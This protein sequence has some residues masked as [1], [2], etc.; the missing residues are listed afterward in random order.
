MIQKRLNPLYERLMMK[1]SNKQKALIHVAKSK[2]GLSEDGYRDLLAGFGVES[3]RDLSIDNFDGIMSRLKALGFESTS[4]YRRPAENKRPL[5]SKVHALMSE[6]N[7]TENYVDGMTKRMFR[8]D[9]GEPIS[10]FRWLNNAQLHSL[11]AALNYHRR[12]EE[13]RKK[14]G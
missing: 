10:S 1:I 12:R 13:K 3:S 7:L 8:N 9:H 5:M 4:R 14:Q 11:V 2:I 6:L